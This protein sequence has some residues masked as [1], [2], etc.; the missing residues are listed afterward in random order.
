MQYSSVCTYV[1]LSIFIN[2]KFARVT[3]HNLW[4]GKQVYSRTV[5]VQ[6]E[7][8]TR[9]YFHNY[10]SKLSLSYMSQS[11]LIQDNRASLYFVLHAVHFLGLFLVFT[12]FLFS[13]LP[14]TLQP[15]DNHQYK[16]TQHVVR[17][18]P[19]ELLIIVIKKALSGSSVLYCF[20]RRF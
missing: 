17:P 7:I 16:L 20:I 6:V 1:N 12:Q 13:V 11:F 5:L 3:L 9:T 18:Y 10:T 4:Q 2:I 14:T 15:S 19:K 8:H